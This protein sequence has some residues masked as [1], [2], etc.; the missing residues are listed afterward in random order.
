MAGRIPR[1]LW[2]HRMKIEGP[3]TGIEVPCERI[4][5]TLPKWFGDEDSLLAYARATSHQP[6]FVVSSEGRAVGFLSLQAHFPGSWEVTCIAVD[7]EHR[8]QGL[9]KRLH[10]HAE[11]WLVS[12][13]ASLLQ[14][15]T[16][17]ASHPSTAYAQTRAFYC[18]LGYQPVEVFPTLWA[19]HLPVLQLIKAL[20]GAV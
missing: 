3:L 11:Q 8:G 20:P 12:Q 18:A 19:A 13:G 2:T 7:A 17:A 6:S 15:K 1:T 4:L 16:L 5:R 10:E 14:V 9:G